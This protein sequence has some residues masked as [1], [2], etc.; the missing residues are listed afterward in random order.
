MAGGWLG[1]V[2]ICPPAFAILQVGGSKKEPIQSADALTQVFVVIRS[3][4][5]NV[6]STPMTPT[7]LRRQTR[8]ACQII[9]AILVATTAGCKK[10]QSAHFNTLTTGGQM[11]RFPHDDL[12]RTGWGSSKGFLRINHFWDFDLIYSDSTAWINRNIP[13][14]NM[15]PN[16][17]RYKDPLEFSAEAIDG[18]D[19]KCVKP[20]LNGCGF[21][22]D[23]HG[24]VWSVEFDTR[25]KGES[26][27]FAEQAKR[28]LDDHRQ[29]TK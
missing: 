12:F 16:N 5:C 1:L 25:Y 18:I 13:V 6:L 24:A 8:L 9:L 23:D 3:P 20:P 4:A 29:V 17:V 15:M 26:K 14:Q 10:E 27:A 22:I 2:D 7:P 21:I 28:Y 19:V 11:Y